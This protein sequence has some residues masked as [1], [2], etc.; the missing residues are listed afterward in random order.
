MELALGVHAANNI[1]GALFVT[2]EGSVLATPA[3]FKVKEINPLMA[4]IFGV[5]ACILFILLMTKILDWKDWSKL[6]G[7][8]KKPEGNITLAEE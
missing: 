5:I 4:N 3:L 6:Y 7:K 1:F 8:T 2:F